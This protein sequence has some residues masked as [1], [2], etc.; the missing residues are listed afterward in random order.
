MLGLTERHKKNGTKGVA[1]VPGINNSGT[2]MSGFVQ[3]DG[4]YPTL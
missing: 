3:I 4:D 2:G 1:L